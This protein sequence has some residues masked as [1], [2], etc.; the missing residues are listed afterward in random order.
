MRKPA[1]FESHQEKICLQGF[2]PSLTPT[3][4]YSK[5]LKNARSL[6]IRF[7]KRLNYLSN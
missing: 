4:L 6:K 2:I 5:K 3:D 1:S 7:K